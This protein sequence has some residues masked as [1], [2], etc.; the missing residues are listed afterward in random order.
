[1]ALQVMNSPFDKQQVDLLN[2]LLTNLSSTQRIWLTGYLSAIPEM[3]E[4]TGLQQETNVAVESVELAQASEEITV[5]YGS[6][7]GN[8]EQLAETFANELKGQGFDVDVLSTAEFRPNQLRK[9]TQL[10][11]IIST[12]GE[13]DPPD[14]ALSFYEFLFGKRAPELEQLNYSVLSLGDSSYEHFCLTGKEIDERLADLKATR[15][16]PRIDCDLDY[17]ELANEWYKQVE[18]SLKELIGTSQTIQQPTELQQKVTSIYTRTN[19]FKAEVLENIN[20][21]GKGSNKETRHIELLLEDSNLMYEPG[22][23]IGILPENDPQLV[24]D[25]IEVMN[26]DAAETL[27]IKEEERTVAEA[28]STYYEITVLTKPLLTKLSTTFQNEKLAR[29]LEDEDALKD[30]L[31]NYDLLDL[32]IDFNLTEVSAIELTPLLR[33]MPARLYS[34][35]SSFDANPDEVHLTIG[36][37]RYEAGNRNRKGVCSVQCAERIEVGDTLNI[38]VHKNSNFRLPENPNTPIIMI[39]PGTGVA[40][41]RAFMEEREETAAEGKSWMFFGDQ[42]YVTDFLYQVEWQRW[43]QNGVLTNLDVAF[44]RDTNEKVY[45][46]HRMKQH[47]KE[48]FSWLEEGAVVYVC[49]DEAHMAKDVH[50]TLLQIV[51]EEGNLSFDEAED[52]I[53]VMQQNKR[54]QRDVY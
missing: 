19:P 1:M 37:V 29:L 35:A 28:L 53:K 17:D 43:L 52:Y 16:S 47:Q 46:Q 32:V 8:A 21:N 31:A 7:T 39:G 9:I 51:K 11:I 22:D 26:W 41:F 38:Y 27:T 44:S 12:H 54:Y 13:G 42:H 20:L 14:N 18:T 30:Y 10:L 50:D 5:L 45:V 33:K 6:Q 23:S 34:V 36:T 24:K 25:F 4:I 48:L 49:G 15:I 2:K 40:P 3:E